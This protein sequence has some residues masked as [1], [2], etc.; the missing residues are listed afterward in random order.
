MTWVTIIPKLDAGLQGSRP[1]RQVPVLHHPPHHHPSQGAV[2]WQLE[3]AQVG[4]R[5]VK[6]LDVVEGG[7]TR[8]SVARKFG[9]ISVEKEDGLFEGGLGQHLAPGWG[10]TGQG[11]E[12]VGSEE[13]PEGSLE[14]AALLQLVL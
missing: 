4:V 8:E 7:Q 1:C 11:L 12:E 2:Y 3:G 14:V 10:L 9:A 6:V 13:G 5:L